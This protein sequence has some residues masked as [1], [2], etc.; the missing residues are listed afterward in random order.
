MAYIIPLDGLYKQT[1]KNLKLTQGK[2][3]FSFSLRGVDCR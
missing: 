2:C 3:L 1:S